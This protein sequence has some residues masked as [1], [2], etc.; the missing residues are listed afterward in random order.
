MLWRSALWIAA[1]ALLVWGPPAARA[2]LLNTRPVPVGPPSIGAEKTLQSYLD[3]K[4][5]STLD[6]GLDQSPYALFM[7]TGDGASTM[8]LLLEETVFDNTFGIYQFGNP[9][10]RIPVLLADAAPGEVGLFSEVTFDADGVVGRVRVD[11]FDKKGKFQSS[12]TFDSFGGIFGL[13]IEHPA[14]VPREFFSEDS[15]NSD[16]LSHFLALAGNGADTGTWFFGGE[17]SFNHTIDHDY[18]DYAISADFIKPVTSLPPAEVPEPGS[19][20]L[21]GLGLLGLPAVRRG[22]LFHGNPRRRGC[23]PGSS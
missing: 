13:Y 10:F 7:P 4:T 21:L 19:L 6:V 12:A 22:R 9:G 17:D 8:T 3:G 18:N 2:D 5:G 15:L 23:P 1:A 16:G 20:L 11:R 14:S